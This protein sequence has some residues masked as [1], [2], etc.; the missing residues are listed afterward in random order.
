MDSRTYAALKDLLSSLPISAWGIADI[1]GLHPLSAEFP[2]ALS[3][4]VSYTLPSEVYSE[5]E[6]HRLLEENRAG[7][8]AVCGSIS[9]F[10]RSAGIKHRSILEGQDPHTLTAVFPSKLAATR[11]G[12]GWIGKSSLLITPQYGPRVTLA[13][14]LIDSGFPCNEPVAASRCGTCARCVE[15]CPYRC[16]RGIE[17]VPGTPRDDLLDA[18][19]CST[20]REAY[21][22]TIGHKHECGL[23]L[24][25]CPFGKRDR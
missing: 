20:E 12:L 15:A 2:R 24:L 22:S 18:H 19:L 4:L 16:I 5:E 7:V 13:T 25:V 10:L 8:V 1:S 11:A 6:Y 14:L 17:W 9:G 3:I 21:R 23:C